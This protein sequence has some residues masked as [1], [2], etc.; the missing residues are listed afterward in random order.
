MVSRRIGAMEVL[1]VDADDEPGKDSVRAKIRRS[2]IALLSGAEP[3]SES[4]L[5]NHSPAPEIRKGGLWN[6]KHVEEDYESAGLE[7][8]E[9][10]ALHK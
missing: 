4:W 6:V 8:L 9:Q 7:V 1:W 5:G 3:P 10:I 2:A